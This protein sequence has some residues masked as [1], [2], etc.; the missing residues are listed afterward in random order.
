[1]SE[2]EKIQM[3]EQLISDMSISQEDIRSYL[4]LSTDRIFKRIWPFGKSPQTLPAQYDMVQIQL[5]V[6]MIARKGGEGEIAHSENGISRTY[7][8]VDD[9]DILRTL[10]PYVGVVGL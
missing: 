9:E 10:T 6:R 4:A 2:K 7:A 5:T 1:M 3:V 8:T